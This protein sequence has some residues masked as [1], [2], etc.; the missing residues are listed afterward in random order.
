MKAI[1]NNDYYSSSDLHADEIFIITEVGICESSLC[2][3]FEGC[4]LKT[5]YKAIVISGKR[6]S[7]CGEDC[8]IIDNSE[9]GISNQKQTYPQHWF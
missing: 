8:C 1:L 9:I 4:N 3:T 6:F 7:I 2:P 5:F